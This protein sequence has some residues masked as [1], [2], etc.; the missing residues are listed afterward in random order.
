MMTIGRAIAVLLLVQA[1]AGCVSRRNEGLTSSGTGGAGGTGG[2]G[3]GASGAGG[4]DARPGT[5]G[6]ADAA[7]APSS[8]D[9]RADAR[10][11]D[12]SDGGAPDRGDAPVDSSTCVAQYQQ[13]CGA[14]GG[15]IQ[16]N[17]ACSFS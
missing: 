2:G 17:G 15:R 8:T 7:D 14:C 10:G 5:G 12:G 1:A 9:V 11:P 16:C 13:S 6:V 3:G 4:M